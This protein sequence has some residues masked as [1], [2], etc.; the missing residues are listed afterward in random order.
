MSGSISARS[1]AAF[2]QGLATYVQL[3]R[4]LKRSESFILSTQSASNTQQTTPGLTSLGVVEDLPQI[5]GDIPERLILPVL[6]L[7]LDHFET[8]RVFDLS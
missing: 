4:Q 3:L 6:Q 7:G 8:E 2:R 1:A 5:R